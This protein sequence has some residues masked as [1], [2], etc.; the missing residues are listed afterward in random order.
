MARQP[1]YTR[2]HQNIPEYSVEKISREV[3]VKKSNPIKTFR[4]N[5]VVEKHDKE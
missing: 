5:V 4:W 3:I 1:E 2:I